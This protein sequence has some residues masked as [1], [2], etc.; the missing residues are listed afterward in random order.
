MITSMMHLRILSEECGA[1]VT[2]NRKSGAH[3][4]A[5]LTPLLVG[6]YLE[7]AIVLVVHCKDVGIHWSQACLDVLMGRYIWN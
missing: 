7:I 5:H 2:C 1:S 4:G 3:C 6:S